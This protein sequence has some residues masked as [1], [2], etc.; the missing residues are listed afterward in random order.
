MAGQYDSLF[1]K[2]F[3]LIRY[4]DRTNRRST[5]ML[6]EDFMDDTMVQ[7]M[8]QMFA[9]GGLDVAILQYVLNNDHTDAVHVIHKED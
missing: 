1:N 6:R 7:N 8:K 4:V 5:Y 3:V 9:K 2:E